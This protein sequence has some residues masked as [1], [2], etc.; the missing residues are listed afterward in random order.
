M[1]EKLSTIVN[2]HRNKYHDKDGK[3]MSD[4][5]KK[6]T[7]H[8]LLRV[9]FALQETMT[10]TKI[11]ESFRKTGIYPFDLETILGNCT[12]DISDDLKFKIV[13]LLPK[14]VKEM[15]KK[16]EII[17]KSYKSLNLNELYPDNESD[18]HNKDGLCIPR[19][20]ACLLTH[21]SFVED[22]QEKADVER[23]TADERNFRLECNRGKRWYEAIMLADQAHVAD[24]FI[25][26]YVIDD[27]A[28]NITV[29]A[30]NTIVE[31]QN[32]V[33]LVLTLKRRLLE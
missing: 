33:P 6:M 24:Q 16:G 28:N 7:V 2:T 10:P 32:E 5:H 19:R 12:E 17:N 26:N 31:P 30:P 18:L 25:A 1:I 11:E 9:Q 14:L 8:G 23:E 3:K 15:D 20:R 21:N 27:N 13:E 22:V 4:A 29:E